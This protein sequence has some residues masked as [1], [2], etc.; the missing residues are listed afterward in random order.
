MDYHAL[1]L[2]HV[3]CVAY[4]LGADLVRLLISRWLIDRHLEATARAQAMH[5][6]QVLARWQLLCIILA[7]PSGLTLA[8]RSGWLTQDLQGILAIWAFCAGWLWIA[9]T[10]R[11]QQKG[12]REGIAR[13]DVGLPIAVMLGLCWLAARSVFGSGPISHAPWL[14][15]KVVLYVASLGLLLWTHLR[16]R[17]IGT[18]CARI[19]SGSADAQAELDLGRIVRRSRLQIGVLWV[20]MVLSMILG[21]AK[22]LV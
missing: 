2:L 14:L 13:L 21:Q 1:V 9:W 3:L 11:A 18:L 15:A 17:E 6:W 20:L 8:W 7:L 10:S 22:L 4:A 5:L 19:V 16:S 12:T